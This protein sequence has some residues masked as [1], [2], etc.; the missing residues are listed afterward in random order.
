MAVEIF[1]KLDGCNGEAIASGHESEIDVLGWHWGVTNQ[2]S[3]HMGGG[4]GTGKA[5]FHD[6]TVTKYIDLATTTILSNCSKGK[7][8][9]TATLTARK[10]GGDKPLEYLTITMSQVFISGVQ[11][12][13]SQGDER[14]TENVTL[15]FEKVKVDYKPQSVSGSGGGDTP[16][17]WDIRKNEAA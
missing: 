5:N 4:A 2:G 14:T 1:L 6:L 8:F 7:H 11:H 3:A 9:S 13:G 12:G 17:N 15:N 10:V 16:F